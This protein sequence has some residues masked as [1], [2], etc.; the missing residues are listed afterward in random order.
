MKHFEQLWEES[1]K[2]AAEVYT[3]TLRDVFTQITILINDNMTP[4]E[5]GELL[6]LIT[7]LSQKFNINVYQCLETEIMDQKISLLEPE[8]PA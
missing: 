3:G 5:M 4:K 1:E 6:F 2:L 8:E 7:F